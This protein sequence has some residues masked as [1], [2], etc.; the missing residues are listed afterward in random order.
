V[1]SFKVWKLVPRSAFVLFIVNAVTSFSNS[2]MAPVVL[3]YVIEDLGISPIDWSRLL[4]F[5]FVSMIF[6][7]I[8][9]GK[10]VGR[11]AGGYAYSYPKS[12]GPSILLLIYETSSG[13]T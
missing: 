6:L 7:S 13:C 10:I 8:P 2:I 11:L 12:C 3:L 5:L 1:E 9:V 4:T